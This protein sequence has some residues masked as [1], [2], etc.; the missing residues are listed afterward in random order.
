[1]K[2]KIDKVDSLAGHTPTPFPQANLDDLAGTLDMAG[3]TKKNIDSVVRVVNSHEALLEA[4]DKFLKAIGHVTGIEN[5]RK[6]F[7][8]AINQAEKGA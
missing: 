8:K 4:S 1:M 2:T 7:I 3:W 6:E 5:A